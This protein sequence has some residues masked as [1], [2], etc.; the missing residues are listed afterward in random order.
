MFNHLT[1]KFFKIP[2]NGGIHF[3]LTQ[4]YSDCAAMGIMTAYS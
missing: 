3:Q 2:P 1:V 4:V